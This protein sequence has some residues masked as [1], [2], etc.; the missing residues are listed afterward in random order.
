MYKYGNDLTPGL[1]E[2][3]SYAV[4]VTSFPV[5][6]LRVRFRVIPALKTA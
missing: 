1:S 3:R 6:G 5:E 2:V 4:F